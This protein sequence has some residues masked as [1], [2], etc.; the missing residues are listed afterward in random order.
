[1]GF[2][3]AVRKNIVGVRVEDGKFPVKRYKSSLS[4]SLSYGTHILSWP[5]TDSVSRFLLIVAWSYSWNLHTNRTKE[6]R[7]HHLVGGFRVQGVSCKDRSCFTR[8]SLLLLTLVGM[9]TREDFK[10]E[11]F[12]FMSRLGIET[13]FLWGWKFAFGYRVDQLPDV[14]HDWLHHGEDRSLEPGRRGRGADYLFYNP[15][16]VHV[17]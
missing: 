16:N 9:S 3:V 10:L 1:M 5:H 7:N 4:A 15:Y 6:L 2:V 11:G 12:A 17:I 14:S 13:R 8:K